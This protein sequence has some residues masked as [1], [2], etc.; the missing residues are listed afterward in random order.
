MS[1]TRR[2]LH[3]GGVK[4]QLES[5]NQLRIIPTIMR[6]PFP[7][8]V[9]FL[10]GN[11]INFNCAELT[12]AHQLLGPTSALLRR[13]RRHGDRI[14]FIQCRHHQ[15]LRISKGRARKTWKWAALFLKTETF[16]RRPTKTTRSLNRMAIAMNG[17]YEWAIGSWFYST[18]L[19]LFGTKT[20][21][22]VAVGLLQQ[23]C[24]SYWV[25]FLDRCFI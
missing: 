11:A 25:A 8:W 17:S 10:T 24:R 5:V 6:I 20:R 19:P 9:R 21:S 18:W 2:K 1:L 16:R 7:L 12:G 4:V 22:N 14:T 15:L 3:S 23:C 13:R